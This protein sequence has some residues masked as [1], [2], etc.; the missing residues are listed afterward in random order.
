MASPPQTKAAGFR[1]SMIGHRLFC[2]SWSLQEPKAI[3]LFGSRL[4]VRNLAPCTVIVG[5]PAAVLTLL[6]IIARSCVCLRMIAD[7]VVQQQVG[8]FCQ[9]R[10][11]MAD[12]STKC[13]TNEGD[14]YEEV[15]A[16]DGFVKPSGQCARQKTNLVS[17]W[18]IRRFICRV[19]LLI[20]PERR[21][22][23]GTTIV[24]YNFVRSFL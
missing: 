4:E 7:Q 20:S 3:R 15:L 23:F 22:I 21:R 8:L 14:S 13:L 19:N 1:D 10:Q 11:E 12:T 16:W 24:L 5:S 9:Q 6:P 17:R 18:K 2:E